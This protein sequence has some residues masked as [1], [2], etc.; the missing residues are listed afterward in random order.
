VA[1]GVR[2]IV[3]HNVRN[4]AD[5]GR[6]GIEAITPAEMLWKLRGTT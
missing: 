2:Y 6:F 5:V 1:A 4:F 3:T